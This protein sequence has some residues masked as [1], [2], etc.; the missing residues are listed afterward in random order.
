MLS[1]FVFALL[2][3][4]THKIPAKFEKYDKFIADRT[5]YVITNVT[6]KCEYETYYFTVSHMVES[7]SNIWP[8]E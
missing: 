8:S 4:C 5:V 7:S 6:D 2:S 3:F 1:H